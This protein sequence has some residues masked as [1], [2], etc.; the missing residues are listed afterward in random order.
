MILPSNMGVSCNISHEPTVPNTRIFSSIKCVLRPDFEFWFHHAKLLKTQ[1][2]EVESIA[3]PSVA[4]RTQVCWRVNLL[5]SRHLAQQTGIQQ[6]HS[7]CFHFEYIFF[8]W[9]CLLH[10]IFIVYYIKLYYY[11]SV[12]SPCPKDHY[13]F[14]KL[15]PCRKSQVLV[16][17]CGLQ[18]GPRPS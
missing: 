4:L 13:F 9:N 8:T 11:F 10:I 5:P 14:V 7:T 12:A 6:V 15:K 1:L 3:Q 17:G 18:P 2:A 16:A